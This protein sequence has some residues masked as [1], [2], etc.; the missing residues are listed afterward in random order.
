M[1]LKKFR[2]KV[3]Y[4]KNYHYRKN[5]HNQ[6]FAGSSLLIEREKE[7]FEVITWVLYHCN[8]LLIKNIYILIIIVVTCMH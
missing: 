5:P 2:R 4:F 3:F 7:H 8:N 1:D 6:I